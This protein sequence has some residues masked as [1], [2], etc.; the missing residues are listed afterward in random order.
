MGC[1]GSAQVNRSCFVA[2]LVDAA[3]SEGYNSAR[4]DCN[5]GKRNLQEA[6]ANGSGVT[7]C[8]DEGDNNDANC[9]AKGCA[10]ELVVCRS[11]NLIFLVGID[12]RDADSFNVTAVTVRLRNL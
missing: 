7:K 8:Y 12:S 11:H 4:N 1:V 6:A 10:L 2:R 3:S 9:N 5:N